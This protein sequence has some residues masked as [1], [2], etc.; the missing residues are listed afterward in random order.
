MCIRD[1]G[2][3]GDPESLGEGEQREAGG[4]GHHAH[5]QRQQ[6]GGQPVGAGVG[7]DE[8]LQQ[9]PLGDEARGCLLYTSRCV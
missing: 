6:R 8:G 9:A 5:D 3:G 4:E 2:Q 1:R 7:V